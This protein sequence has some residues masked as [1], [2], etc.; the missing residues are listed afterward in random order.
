MIAVL[1]AIL[2]LAFQPPAAA[3]DY[4]GLYEKGVPFARFLADATSLKGE[5][6]ANF[7]AATIEDVSLGRAKALEGPWRILVVAEDSCHDS[8][9]TLPYLAKLVD[10]SPDTLS[11]RVV[12]KAVGLPVMEAHRTPD[13]RAATPT[14]VVLDAEGRVKGVLAERPAALWEFSKEHSARG[15]RRQWYAED[16]GRHAIAEILDL[17]EK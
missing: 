11:M 1:L 8:L 4:S 14:I 15:E 9:G 10:A 7:A 6:D 17:I 12:R 3:P 2:S 16:K 5:W 13:G